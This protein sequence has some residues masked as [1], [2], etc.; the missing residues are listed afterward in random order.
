MTLRRV[1]YIK[2]Q[3]ALYLRQEVVARKWAPG[4]NPDGPAPNALKLRRGGQKAHVLATRDE[5]ARAVHSSGAG[6]AG[7]SSP[8]AHSLGRRRR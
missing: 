8:A 1:T 6:M 5:P 2:L 7:P 3:Y 4:K